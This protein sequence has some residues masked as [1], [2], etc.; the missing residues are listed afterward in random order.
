[1]TSREQQITDLKSSRSPNDDRLSFFPQ[2]QWVLGEDPSVRRIALHAERASEVE[3]T[4]LVT[5]ETGTG[6]EV[7]ANLIH[8]AGPRQE[9]S[10]VPVNCAALTPSL[11]E[12][13]LFGHENCT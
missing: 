9:K 10:F 12:G 13:Q 4:V 2:D 6:K 11:A 8:Q 5:G 7:W 3:C 1:M